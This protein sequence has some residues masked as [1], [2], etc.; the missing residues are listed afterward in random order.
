[1]KT[2]QTIM[3]CSIQT[4]YDL[5]SSTNVLQSDRTHRKYFLHI[6]HNR[7]F[8]LRYSR[9]PESNYPALSQ[10][11]SYQ[12]SSKFILGG[13]L[14]SFSVE[15]AAAEQTKPWRLTDIDLGDNCDESFDFDGRY[16]RLIH[17]I[18]V[19]GATA[20]GFLRPVEILRAKLACNAKIPKKKIKKYRF[21]ARQQRFLN[22]VPH[23]EKKN[24][25]KSRGASE[26]T[27]SEK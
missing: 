9:I 17:Q 12:D 7:E 13:G 5:R 15:L 16:P 11:G 24:K 14:T 6:N 27:C 19:G 1:M 8:N 4:A 23:R 20:H 18:D 22:L 21:S 10:H 3:N 26:D 2:R 25:E